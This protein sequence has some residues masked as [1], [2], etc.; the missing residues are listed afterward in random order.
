MKSFLIFLRGV[1]KFV[2]FELRKDKDMGEGSVKTR[3]KVATSFMDGP[4]Y[5]FYLPDAPNA[6]SY[7]SLVLVSNISEDCS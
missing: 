3:E 2:K 7:F 1:V 4:L 6:F 5:D